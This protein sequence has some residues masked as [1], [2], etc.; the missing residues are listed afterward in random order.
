MTRVLRACGVVVAAFLLFSAAPIPKT[1]RPNILLIV[2][3]TLRFDAVNSETTPFVASLSKR[4]IVFTNAYSTHDFTPTSHFSMFTGLRNGLGGELDGA[5]LGVPYQLQRAGYWTFATVANDLIGVRANPNDLMSART[6]IDMRLAMYGFRPTQHARAIAYFNA[7][8]LLPLFAEQ[9]RTAKAPYFGFVNL[10]DPHEPFIPDPD[11]YPPESKLPPGF[12][13]DVLTRR[14]SPELEHP[15]SIADPAR[16]KFVQSLVDT[17]KFARL[18]AIDLS[19]AA[20][21]IYHQRYLA[22]VKKTDAMLKLFFDDLY[23]QHALDNTVVILTSD[24]GEEFG[25]SHFITHMLQDKGDYEA[26]HHVPLLVIL[27]PRMA[28]KAAVVDR[29]V[30][31]DMIAPTIYDFAGVDATPLRTHLAG[32]APPPPPPIP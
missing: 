22:K 16:R 12:V 32:F 14:V 2:V 4:S 28:R 8:R 21:Q 23:R 29:E 17:V 15:E 27:P 26:T 25:E 18:V 6:R 1:T 30:S 9:I 5:E 7:G 20:L 3:D 10:I 19:P 11:Y 13:A 31:I 24:H